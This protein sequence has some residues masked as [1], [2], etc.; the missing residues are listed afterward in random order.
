[1]STLDALQAALAGEHACVYGYGLLGAHAADG[2]LDDVRAA[3]EVHRE[4][5]RELN[6]QIQIRHGDPVAALPAYA[7]PF[8]VDGPDA[9]RELAGLLEQRLAVLYADVVAVTSV[10]ALREYAAGVLVDT[11]VLATRW[12]RRTTALPGLDGVPEPSG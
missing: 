9:A 10:P 5:R 8:D 6:H 11:A 4:R 3:Y 1:M 7:V 12:T 2:D